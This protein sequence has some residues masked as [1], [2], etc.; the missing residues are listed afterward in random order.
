MSSWGPVGSKGS[1]P[2]NAYSPNSTACLLFSDGSS[3]FGR[4]F[5]AEKDASG[6]LVFTTSMTGFQESLT[7][8]SYAGQILTF[9]YPLIGN[10]GVGNNAFESLNDKVWT[11]GVVVKEACSSPFHYDSKENLAAFLKEQGIPAIE[12][13]DTRALVRKIREHGVVPCALATWEGKI[14]QKEFEIKRDYLLKQ[15]GKFDYSK[16]NFVELASVKTKMD[17]KAKN[18]KKKIALI[19]YGAKTGI[20][21]NFLER[22]YSVTVF[23]HS[24]KASEI[25]DDGFAGVMLSNG[26]GDPSVLQKEI[27][28]I[29]AMLGQLPIFGICLGHQLLGWA[30]GGK[31]FKLKFGHRGANHAVV[32]KTGRAFVTSQNH[33]FALDASSLNGDCTEKFTNCLD[34]TNEGLESKKNNVFSIQFHPEANPGPYDANKFFDEF[35]KSLK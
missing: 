28:E 15:L 2:V 33:G 9:S 27:K 5:G 22:G 13:V 25:L 18:E 10:Y 23:P 19:D 1:T 29:K 32:D 14:S 31:T 3:V 8:P 7:D 11:N 17:F 35:L 26:P 16:V 12:N 21:R 4:S 30:F 20:V 24:V 6:E 34:G